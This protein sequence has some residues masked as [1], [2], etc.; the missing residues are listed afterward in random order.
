MTDSYSEALEKVIDKEDTVNNKMKKFIKVHDKIKYEA[1]GK[2]TID[3]SKLGEIRK[4]I[5]I[6]H[7]NKESDAEYIHKEI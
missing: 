7:E 5:E 6:D 1:F 2:V 3:S 4:H